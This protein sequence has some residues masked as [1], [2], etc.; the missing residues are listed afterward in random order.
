MCPFVTSDGKLQGIVVGGNFTSLGGVQS[1]GVALFN[2]N[3]S[4]IVPLTGIEGTVS[5]VYCDQPSNTVYVGGS[6]RGGN[7]TNA[8]AWVTGWTNLPF[9]G[10]N[11]PVTSITKG[12][13]GSIIFG[14]SFDSLGNASSSVTPENA[15]QQV[16]PVTSANISVSLSTTQTGFDDPRS[17]ICKTASSAGS[18][19]TWLLPDRAPGFWRADFQFGF[20]P[21]KLMLSNANVQNRGVKTWRFT[22]LP[23]TG[24]MNFTYFDQTGKRQYCDA[25]C[26]LANNASAQSFSFVNPNVGMNAFR[27]DISDWY[28]DGA[29]LSG[30]ELFQ[31][32]QSPPGHFS[33]PITC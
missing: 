25:N 10:F 24:I 33:P 28:G 5:A 9:A 20:N 31:D 17:I 27:I 1:T 29:G 30:I 7:S 21:T 19:N 13:N 11:K 8:I 26:P 6:F 3:N 12:S 4:Q 14:G 15:D 32:G 22:A 2:P 23:D 16:I 18:G